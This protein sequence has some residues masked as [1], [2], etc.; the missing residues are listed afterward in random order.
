M[1][2][3]IFICVDVETAGPIPAKYAMLS[4]GACLVTDIS[5]NYYVEL[6]PDHKAFDPQAL[7]ISGLELDTLAKTGVEPGTAMKN[8]AEWVK[9]RV[10]EDKKPVLVAL[11]APFDWS[12]VNDYFIRYLGYNPFGHSALDIK[13]YYMGQ[14]GVNWSETSMKHLSSHFL[15]EIHLT[16][17][18]LRDAQDQAE[19]FQKILAQNPKFNLSE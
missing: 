13:A 6:K 9:S 1:L 5:V 15:E 16:H 18:A 3:E 17:N 14:M 12:F 2:E 10:M 19:I 11:N 7:A 8:F 4:I